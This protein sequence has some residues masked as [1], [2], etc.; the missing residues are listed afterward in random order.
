MNIIIF[1]SLEFNI[2]RQEHKSSFYCISEIH[3]WGNLICK[4]L[5]PTAA[6]PLLDLEGREKMSLL[7]VSDSSAFHSPHKWDL[8]GS[9][10]GP[11]P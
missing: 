6:K 10:L 3:L 1:M 8:Q 11:E 7:V 5:K 9:G 2:Y 4:S